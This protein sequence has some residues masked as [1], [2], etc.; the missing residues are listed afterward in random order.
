MGGANDNPGFA[1]YSTQVVEALLSV[2]E[3]GPFTCQDE[4]N[5]LQ[6]SYIGIPAPCNLIQPRSKHIVRG[7]RHKLIHDTYQRSYIEALYNSRIRALGMVERKVRR[8]QTLNNKPQS[9]R[10]N[11][12]RSWNTPPFAQQTTAAQQHCLSRPCG[13]GRSATSFFRARQ[14]CHRLPC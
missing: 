4:A 2:D 10:S 11:Q 12:N 13:S 7:N 3:Q 8:V 5:V 1:S 14:G 9:L 6:V